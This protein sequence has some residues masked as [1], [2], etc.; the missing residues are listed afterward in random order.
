MPGTNKLRLQIET[1][2]HRRSRRRLV[3]R[4]RPRHKLQSPTYNGH[5]IAAKQNP[6]LRM[7]IRDVSFG[8]PTARNHS[9]SARH[10]VA[11]R[12]QRLSLHRR[13]RSLLQQTA[14]QNQHSQLRNFLSQPPAQPKL[15]GLTRHKWRFDR[16]VI[17]RH[18]QSRLH[19]SRPRRVIV[20]PVRQQHG[21]QFVSRESEARNRR[22]KIR[23]TGIH[24][25][26]NRDQ[27]AIESRKVGT[28]QIRRPPHAPN[29]LS[30]RENLKCDNAA[31]STRI[32]RSVTH[33]VSSQFMTLRFSVS[34]VS[35]R[36]A[37]TRNMT[38][39][40]SLHPSSPSRK[41]HHLLV[42]PR[43]YSFSTFT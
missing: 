3:Q 22:K 33:P 41:P 32:A 7:K 28:S 8:V 12:K 15:R 25:G 2:H 35:D 43:L 6:A 23:P 26:I 37:F 11:I 42:F 19:R 20:V 1:L 9:E 21:F 30:H 24:P 4:H 5:R 16:R 18:I 10:T 34:N 38:G 13:R 36:P 14:Q 39:A 17:N 29:I 27:I 31:P 40:V